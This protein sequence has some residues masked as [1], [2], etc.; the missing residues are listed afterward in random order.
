MIIKIKGEDG[1]SSTVLSRFVF[2]KPTHGAREKER[3]P[4]SRFPLKMFRNGFRLLAEV[5]LQQALEGFT[6]S[7]FVW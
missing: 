6:M 4:V 2:H 1:T 7:S 3:E 5:T